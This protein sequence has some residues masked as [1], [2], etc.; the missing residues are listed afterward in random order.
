MP[1]AA[2]GLSGHCNGYRATVAVICNNDTIQT[3]MTD[4]ESLP[5]I[6]EQ[7]EQFFTSLGKVQ[8]ESAI[9][10]VTKLA[11]RAFAHALT[12]ANTSITTVATKGVISPRTATSL[13][14]P[15]APEPITSYIATT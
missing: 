14:T 11:D 3:L 2:L 5:P 1:I 9:E 8:H 4:S 7:P 10:I 12:G 15:K 6:E 13:T